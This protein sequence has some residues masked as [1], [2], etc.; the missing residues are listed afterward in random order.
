MKEEIELRDPQALRALAHPVRIRLLGLLRRDGPLTASAAGRSLGE[1]SGS[2]SYH[3]RQLARFGLVEEAG[4]GS[5]RERP[6]QATALTTSWPN[7]ADTPEF[8]AASEALER[9]VLGRYV[10]RLDGWV[11]RRASEPAEW[12]EAATFGDAVLY[13]TLDELTALRD[14]LRHLFDRYVERYSRAELRPPGARPVALLQ[15]AFPDEET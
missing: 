9:F 14:D 3:L 1:S 7:V 10:E 6:W 15:I 4:G 13:L 12:Q 2:T 8:A 5:G 11:A